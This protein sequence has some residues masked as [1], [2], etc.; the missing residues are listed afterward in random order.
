[1]GRRGCARC[2]SPL[3]TEPDAA[4]DIMFV[5]AGGTRQQLI[6]PFGSSLMGQAWRW[7][8]GQMRKPINSIRV[9]AFNLWNFETKIIPPHVI[10]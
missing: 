8:E 9:K 6:G 10:L 7:Q 1:V 5:K 3:T 2:G 4:P